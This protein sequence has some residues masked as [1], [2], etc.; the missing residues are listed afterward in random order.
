MC[1]HS[2]SSIHEM[3]VMINGSV[4]WQWNSAARQITAQTIHQHVPTLQTYLSTTH[5]LP[6]LCSSLKYFTVNAAP[7]PAPTVWRH[8][9]MAKHWLQTSQLWLQYLMLI[10]SGNLHLI[11]TNICIYFGKACIY[12]TKLQ[13]VY[14]HTYIHTVT[15]RTILQLVAIY[16]IKLQVSGLYVSHHQVV[17]RIWRGYTVCVIILE[18]WRD[19]VLHNKFGISKSCQHLYWCVLHHVKVQLFILWSCRAVK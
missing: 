5:L 12:N 16:N 17:Q 1:R 18:G 9:K 2:L 4:E 7:P 8:V 11:Y 15:N 6:A 14:I 10:F 3:K 13:C 19:L